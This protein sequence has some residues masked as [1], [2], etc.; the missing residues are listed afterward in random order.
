M[1]ASNWKTM[2]EEAASGQ[3]L[4][5]GTMLKGTVMTKVARIDTGLCFEPGFIE[6]VDGFAREFG[7]QRIELPGGTAVAK[8]CYERA[9]SR[10]LAAPHGSARP[11][12]RISGSN[13]RGCLAA[14]LAICRMTRKKFL[15]E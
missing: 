3:R 14:M 12:A 7:L 9:K 2:G 11:S 4:D 15:G 13:T 5:L 8:G 6:K 1:W 10:L